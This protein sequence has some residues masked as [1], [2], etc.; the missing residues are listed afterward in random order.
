MKAPSKEE[1]KIVGFFSVTLLA[2]GIT[3]NSIFWHYFQKK[4]SFAEMG[5]DKPV[6]LFLS[7]VLIVWLIRRYPFLRPKYEKDDRPVMFLQITN[8]AALLVGLVLF[9]QLLIHLFLLQGPLTTI[10]YEFFGLVALACYVNFVE[11]V[12]IPDTGSALPAKEAVKSLTQLCRLETSQ[13]LFF[14]I[15]I[16]LWEKRF[17]AAVIIVAAILLSIISPYFYRETEKSL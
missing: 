2:F 3:L 16:F 7:G 15:A 10:F 5:Y 9:C 6:L 4:L 14:G 8:L 17:A 1:M 13:I 11:Q 12:I